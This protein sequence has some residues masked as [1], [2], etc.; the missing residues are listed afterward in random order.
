MSKLGVVCLIWSAGALAAD[1]P[2]LPDSVGSVLT[3]HGVAESGVSIVVREL[4]SDKALLHFNA[5]KTRNPASTIKL[6]TTWLAL[7]ELGPAFKWPTEAYLAGE[8]K[9]DGTLDGDLIVKGYGDPYL[10][11]ERLWAFQRRLK[12]RGLRHISGD[13]VID[14]SYFA[15]EYT[16]PG[17]FDG[18]NLRSYNVAPNAFLVNFQA[19]H[20]L[21]EPDLGNNRVNVLVDPLPVNLNIDNQLRLVNG[22][23]GGYQNGISVV[24]TESMRRNN[25]VL[26]GKFGRGCEKYEMTRSA[27]TAP[28]F[29]Y[30]VFKAL[31]EESAGTLAGGWREG[32]APVDT[33]PFVRIESPPMSDVIEYVNKFSNNVMARHL[34][35][36]LGAIA[37]EPPATRGKG[38]QAIQDS[39][40]RRGLTFDGLHVDNGAGL[41][42]KTRIKAKDLAEILAL[43]ANSPWA[44]EYIS[45]FS[46]SGLDGTMQ[47]RFAEEEL[48]GRMHLKTGRLRDVFATAG[49]VHARSG[50][51]YAVVIL[52]NFRGAD[53]GPGEAVQIAL[54]RW[55]YEQ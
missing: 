43:A 21:Y 27:L 25:I 8:L 3:R 37:F 20:M 52:Q 44:P 18:E 48:T 30:G 1:A 46:L 5:D 26:S 31:W 6:L 9:D 55:V 4:G 16:D 49:Y 10:I 11:T 54:L 17:K 51:D 2:R 40:R 50:K 47:K 7:E 38:Q 39:L 53:N 45:S 24:A 42:R 23:C 12:Q 15:D 33:E 34:L 32:T 28:S 41:S 19:M 22:F 13:L 29:G 14:S 35:L 36:T